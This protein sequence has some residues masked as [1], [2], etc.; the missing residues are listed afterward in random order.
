MAAN[1]ILIDSK[2]NP[3][4]EGTDL[5]SNKTDEER[6]DEKWV[7][8]LVGCHLWIASR[9]KG[10]G[11]GCWNADG[12]AMGAHRW[13]YTR[14]K[15]AI[16]DG[17]VLDHLCRVRHCVNPDHLEAVTQKVNAQRGM[18]GKWLRKKKFV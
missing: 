6:F 18:A 14:R 7:D 5:R 13:N 12:R 2:G 11:Y 3:F 17:L 8:S 10:T 15:G 9:F 16:P 1:R 4:I